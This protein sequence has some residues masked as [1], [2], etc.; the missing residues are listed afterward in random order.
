MSD[1]KKKTDGK[2]T[3]YFERTV[4]AR[5]LALLIDALEVEK[6]IRP[7][8]EQAIQLVIEQAFTSRGLALSDGPSVAKVDP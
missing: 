7:T 6:G 2:K 3:S 5:R 8:K 1:P 4:D